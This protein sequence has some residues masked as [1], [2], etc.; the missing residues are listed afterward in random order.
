M[1]QKSAKHMMFNIMAA[2][3]FNK[4][5]NQLWYIADGELTLSKKL[6]NAVMRKLNS[7]FTSACFYIF[8]LYTVIYIFRLL[9]R[10]IK[11]KTQKKLIYTQNTKNAEYKSLTMHQHLVVNRDHIWNVNICKTVVLRVKT[12]WFNATSIACIYLYLQTYFEA[13]AL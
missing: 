9:H 11:H 7:E 6:Y 8:D 13:I 1:P 2:V 10:I 5:I 4:N 3:I 12:K